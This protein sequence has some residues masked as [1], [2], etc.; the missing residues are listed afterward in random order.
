MESISRAISAF[1]NAWSDA[2]SIQNHLIKI[3]YIIKSQYSSWSDNLNIADI[4]D[5]FV[6]VISMNFIGNTLTF[7]SPETNII[8]RDLFCVVRKAIQSMN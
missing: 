6:D 7:D 1:F 4:D 3:T 8:F 2:T 5:K